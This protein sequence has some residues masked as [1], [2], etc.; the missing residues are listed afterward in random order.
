MPL[1]L[2]HTADDYLPLIQG[3]TVLYQG[4]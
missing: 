1:N 2:I 4:T 3:H